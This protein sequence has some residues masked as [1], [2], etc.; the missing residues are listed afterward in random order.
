MP[1]LPLIFSLDNKC[2][3]Y[4]RNIEW[5]SFLDSGEFVFNWKTA[6]QAPSSAHWRRVPYSGW[7]TVLRLCHLATC[8]CLIQELHKALQEGIGWPSYAQLERDFFFLALRIRLRF[9]FF[10]LDRI[11][12]TQFEL[13]T[14][15]EFYS[16]H[17]FL[18]T[19]YCS[20]FLSLHITLISSLPEGFDTMR[21]YL[22]LQ[23]LIGDINISENACAMI[24]CVTLHF[25]PS[26]P[27]CIVLCNCFN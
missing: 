10:G 27:N 8:V 11:K 9:F 6:I 17:V 20:L 13:L 4:E 19:F 18:C 1:Y 23:T 15:N 5:L 14:L 25:R 3:N 12:Q 26:Q 21:R 16:D 7:T 24:A 2:K 22:F